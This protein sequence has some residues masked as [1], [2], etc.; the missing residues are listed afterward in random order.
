M[1]STDNGQKKAF[2]IITKN[3]TYSEDKYVVIAHNFAEAESIYWNKLFGYH[4]IIS[5]N[6]IPDVKDVG[7][8][9]ENR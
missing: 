5:I 8:C 6:V 9:E 3:N 1:S 2:E 4:D 7:Y